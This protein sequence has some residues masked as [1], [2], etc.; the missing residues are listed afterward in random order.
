MMYLAEAVARERGR[1]PLRLA[2]SRVLCQALFFLPIL[3]SLHATYADAAELTADAAA[4]EAVDGA[5]APLASVTT[6][7]GR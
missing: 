1:D 3:R 6:P 4:L 2:V 7:S 5:T